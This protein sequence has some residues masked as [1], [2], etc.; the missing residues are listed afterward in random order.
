M[1]LHILHRIRLLG[2]ITG[3]LSPDSVGVCGYLANISSGGAEPSPSEMIRLASYVGDDR[4]W[5][6]MMGL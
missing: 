4:T 5:T 1:Y 6:R 2:A 3:V